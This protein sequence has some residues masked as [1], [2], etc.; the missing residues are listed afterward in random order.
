MAFYFWAQNARAAQINDFISSNMHWHFQQLTSPDEQS[1]PAGLAIKRTLSFLVNEMEFLQILAPSLF[2]DC[3]C[4]CAVCRASSSV[5][6]GFSGGDKINNGLI[7]SYP[8]I[9]SRVYDQLVKS[10]FCSP[11]ALNKK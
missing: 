11:T 6:V 2:F 7:L 8:W 1:S 9:F 5:P 10:S 3:L 4:A